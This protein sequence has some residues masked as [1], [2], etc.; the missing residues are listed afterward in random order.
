MTPDNSRGQIL[1][2]ALSGMVGQLGLLVNPRR[3]PSSTGVLTLAGHRAAMREVSSWPGYLPTQLIPLDKLADASSIG[4]LWYKD[5]SSR[6]GLGSFKALGGA[7]AVL[8]VMQR[9]ARKRTGR[10]PS[11]AELRARSFGELL[12]DM[13]V[14]TA[15]DGNHG[16]SVAWGAQ[17]FGCRCVVYIP[18]TCSR[19]RETAIA[20]YG[21]TV[22]RTKSGY[23]QTVRLCAADAAERGY[24]VVSDTSWPSYVDVPVDV[25]NG[26]TLMVEEVL[27][28]LSDQQA[29]THV[30]VQGGVG[31]LAASV[32]AHLSN[33]LMKQAPDVVVVEP[34]GA[35]CLFASALAGRPTP[36]P[37]PAAT[38][39]AGLDCAEV[40]TL[41]WEVLEKGAAAF[42]TVE[43]DVVVP[44]MRLLASLSYDGYPI[45]AGES[46]VAGLA[47]VLI[48]SGDP[49]LRH[50]LGLNANSRVLVIGTEGDTD[51]NVY[52]ALVRPATHQ[53]P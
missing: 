17:M 30:F 33:R 35:A 44:C 19:G 12:E 9:E 3:I 23:D 32:C 31:G 52:Q 14:T 51:P 10:E 22:V 15:T 11:S 25:M 42:L 34:R 37:S 45:V 5:E 7:Y 41:A 49:S 8:R 20:R 40:S 13:T 43:D 47:A 21:A 50:I 48:A 36:A 46:A 4:S 24:V 38:I 16:R 2:E 28:Q 6:F 26:Y 29:L 1:S 18:N 27:H 39:M 53:S